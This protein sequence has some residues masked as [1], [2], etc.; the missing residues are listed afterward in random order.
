VPEIRLERARIMAVIRQFVTTS[1]AEHVGM[2]LD[3][4][5]RANRR[6]FDHTREK[7]E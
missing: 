7:I 5:F 3:P 6:P 1:V 4:E 2:D